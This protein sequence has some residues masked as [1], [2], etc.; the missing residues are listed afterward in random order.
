M[1][2]KKKKKKKNLLSNFRQKETKT[3]PLIWVGGESQAS[4]AGWR[5]P[6]SSTKLNP[7][8]DRGRKRRA[9]RRRSEKGMLRPGERDGN[10]TKKLGS[11]SGN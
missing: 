9:E 6:R 11:G 5:T 4:G 2:K 10:A 3:E 1:R 8:A 7:G